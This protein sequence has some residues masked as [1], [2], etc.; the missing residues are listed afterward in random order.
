MAANAHVGTCTPAA[1]TTVFKDPQTA[2]NI[3]T[4]G[5]QDIYYTTDGSQATAGSTKIAAGAA[6]EL[7][8]AT[9]KTSWPCIVSVFASTG[10]AVYSICPASQSLSRPP[11]PASGSL[12]D[13]Y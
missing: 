2:V 7:N 1:H 10:G 11:H 12:I 4:D 5:S 8:V 9:V 6:R 13:R 3:A